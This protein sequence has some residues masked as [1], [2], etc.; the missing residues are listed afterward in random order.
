MET[1]SIVGAGIA[2]LYAAWRLIGSGYPGSAITVYE[3]AD[4]I[5]GR[6]FTKTPTDCIPVDLGAH[7]LRL[8]HQLTAALI[9]RLHLTG[10]PARAGAMTD[11][12]FLRGRWRS[13]AQIRRSYFR[14]AFDYEV[15][16]NIQRRNPRRLL[17]RVLDRYC[18]DGRWNGT[19]SVSAEIDHLSLE[20]TLRSVLTEEEIRFLCD[21]LGYTFFTAPLNARTT[22]PWFDRHFFGSNALLLDGGASALIEAL[23]T[24]LTAAGCQILKGH[25]LVAMDVGRNRLRFECPERTASEVADTRVILALP[26]GQIALV[27]GL[28]E[29]REIR[30]LLQSVAPWPVVTG[31]IWYPD[32][33]WKACGYVTGRSRTDTALGVVRHLV[34]PPGHESMIPGAAA[35]AFYAEGAMCDFWNELAEGCPRGTWMPANHA[36]TRCVHRYLAELYERGFGARAPEPLGGVL[37]PWVAGECGA[38]FHLWRHGHPSSRAAACT[39]LAG[40]D[41]HICGESLSQ[42]QGWIEG[43]LETAEN[44]LVDRFRLTPF[45]RGTTI[46]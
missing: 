42:C 10:T 41:L 3:A 23:E 9:S 39:P 45:C 30:D 1:V 22:L 32:T 7:N 20:E 24:R 26:I 31:A 34:E 17:R 46:V 44:L 19:A 37:Q 13:E 6:I 33:W 14:R 18:E 35:A 36:F 43:A 29:R 21:R 16:W 5:G 25:R 28:G 2:G 12:S 38:A 40:I 8:D 27:D 15:R 11:L 4:R